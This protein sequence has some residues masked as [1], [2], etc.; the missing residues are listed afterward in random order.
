[1]VYWKYIPEEL[2][3]PRYLSCLSSQILIDLWSREMLIVQHWYTRPRDD[4]HRTYSTV[5]QIS[6]AIARLVFEKRRRW[7]ILTKQ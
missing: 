7:Q 3:L 5:G 2:I 1:M 4:V 6:V